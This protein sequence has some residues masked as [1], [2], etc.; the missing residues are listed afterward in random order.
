MT[1]KMYSDEKIHS[2]YEDYMGLKTWPLSRFA[3]TRKVSIYALRHG[4]RR[5]GLEVIP[6]EVTRRKFPVC[7][8]FFESIDSEEKAYCLGFLF[9]DGCNSGRRLEVSLA[10]QD[11]DILE[12][13]SGWLLCGHVNVKEYKSKK[14]NTQNRVAIYVVSKKLCADLEKL[15]CVPR[16]TFV[17]KFPEIPQCLHH[18]FIRGYF[19]GDGSLT[20]Y[21]RKQR[22]SRAACFSIVSTKEMLLAIGS[23]FDTLGVRYE[24]NK[25]HKRRK[26]NNFTLRVHG[27][28]QINTVCNFLYKNATV[29]L[30]RKLK[31]YQ[32]LLE[33]NHGINA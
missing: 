33:I 19:D 29:C 8:T 24:I 1:A 18:H 22:K 20:F 3:K 9:A 27:N 17:L 28:R 21:K 14:K 16:K 23:H 12:I 10:K 15:G 7:D 13:I 11:R 30:A 25:R 26:N 2:L 31:A 6:Q 4:F 32:T 5:L